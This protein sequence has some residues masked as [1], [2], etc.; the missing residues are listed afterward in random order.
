MF[1]GDRGSNCLTL[2]I[3]GPDLVWGIGYD[4]VGRQNL[5]VDQAPDEVMS[6]SKQLGRFRHRQPL[7]I[8]FGG[9]I[10]TDAMYLP[11]R[12]HALRIPRH[13]LPVRMLIRFSD[14]AMC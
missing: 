10:G 4:L 14:A 1:T 3:G 13:T 12:P 2:Q 6:N 7:A 5:F 8:L 11:Q 9:T